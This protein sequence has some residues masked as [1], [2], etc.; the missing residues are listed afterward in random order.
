MKNF[1]AFAIIV[2]FLVSCNTASNE[3]RAQEYQSGYDPVRIQRIKD[4]Q[5]E[6]IDDGLMGSSHVVIYKDGRMIYNQ[7]VNSEHPDDKEITDETIF[8]IWSMSKP[9]T[10]VATMILFEEG[11]FMLDDPVGK[12]IPELNSLQCI[13]NEGNIY[14]CKN[15]ITIR[16]LLTHESGYGYYPEVFEGKFSDLGDFVTKIAEIPLSFEPG[17]EHQYGLSNAILGRL[18]EVLSGQGLYEFLK[19]RIFDPLEMSDTDFDLT[20]D[21]REHFQPLFRLQD[22]SI[23]Y[24]TTEFDELSYQ[25]GSKVQLGGEGLVST[26]SDYCNFCEMLLNNGVFH[27]KRILSPTSISWMHQPQNDAPL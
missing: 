23:G 4:L 13:D 9:I 1:L 18:I 17:T 12:Y 3:S 26:T 15:K 22:T 2:S 27:G 21:E 10:T 14:P 8:P 19:D 5:Q 11:K 16:D 24:Y 25:P 20:A 6:L 7:I